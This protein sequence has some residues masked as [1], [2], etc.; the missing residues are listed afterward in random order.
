MKNKCMLLYCTVLC[1]VMTACHFSD[2]LVEKK[3]ISSLSFKKTSLT[4]SVGASDYVSVVVKPVDLQREANISWTVVNPEI[5]DIIPD[6]YNVVINGK[7]EGSTAVKASCDGI[8]ATLMVTVNGFAQTYEQPP[9]LYS[10]FSV[11]ELQPGNTSEVSVSLYGGTSADLEE[12]SWELTDTSIADIHSA[13]NNCVI[14]AKKTGSAQL[15]ARHPKAH[16]AYTMIVFVYADEL[17]EAYLTT[18][19]NIVTIN[20][21]EE[22]ARNL[23]VNLINPYTVNWQ[24]GFNW[25]ISDESEVGGIGIAANG[26]T[27]ILSAYKAGIYRIT[28]THE[29]VRYPLEILVRVI[30]AVKNVYIVPSETNVIL[31]GEGT[32]TIYAKLE[33]YDGAV[34]FN[35]FAWEWE[36]DPGEILEYSVA[37]DA[38]TL[39]GKKNGV[40]KLHVSHPLAELDRTIVVMLTHQA[41]SAIDSA[42]Y[43]TTSSNYVQ[44]Q[45]GADTTE[46]TVTLAGGVAG[47]EKGFVWSIDKGKDNDVALIETTTGV[48]E[49]RAAIGSYAYGTLHITPK[50]MGEVTVTVSHP[51]VSYTT[52]ILIKVYSE[53]A[54]LSPPVYL[55]TQTSLLKLIN[56]NTQEMSVSLSGGNEAGDENAVVWESTDASKVSVNPRTGSTTVFSACGSGQGQTYVNISH[57]KAQADKKILVLTADTQEE[58]EA[59]KAIFASQTYLRLNVGKENK[60]LLEQIGLTESDIA[61]ITW[62]TDNPS[63]CTVSADMDNRLSATVTGYAK[64]EA[65]ITASF[66]SGVPVEFT[67]TVLPEG[68]DIGVIE[69]AYLTTKQNAVVLSDIG[70]TALLSVTGIGISDAS[71]QAD[72]KWETDCAVVEVSGNGTTASVY[73]AEKGKGTVTVSHPESA[74]ELAIDVKVGALYEWSDDALVYITTES[75]VITLVNGDKKTIGAVLENSQSTAPFSWSCSDTSVADITGSASGTCI[76]TAKQAGQA[77]LIIRNDEAV[78]EKEVLIVVENSAAELG[79]FKYLTTEQNVVTVSENANINVAVSVANAAGNIVSGYSWISDNEAVARVVGSGAMAVVYG[80]KAGTAKVTVRNDQCDYPLEIIVNCVDPVVAA[81]YPYIACKNIVTLTVDGDASVVTA[82]LIG[83]S[84]ADTGGFSW[85]IQDPDMVQLYAANETAELRAKKEGVTQLIIGHPKAQGI[86]RTVLIICEPEKKTDCY[87]SVSESIIKMSPTDREK[88]ISAALIGGEAN[89]V[90]N[91]QWWA[92]DYSILDMSYT[93]EQAIITP[94]A[95]GTTTIHVSHPK[96]GNQ[97]DIVIYISQYDE[98]NFAQQSLTMTAGSRNFVDMEI[99]ALNVKTAVSYSSSNPDVVSAS[100][101]SVC[102]LEAHKKGVATVTAELKATATGVIQAKCE[103]LVNVEEAPQSFTYIN[104]PGETIISIEKKVTKTLS[105]TLAGTEAQTGD[106]DTIQ[107]INNNPDVISISPASASGIVTNSQCQI[108]ALKAGN[109]TITITHEKADQELQLYI[110]VPGDNAASIVLNKTAANVILGADAQTLTATIKNAQEGDYE[111]IIW[112]V[113]QDDDQDPVISISGEGKQIAFLAMKAGSATIKAVVPSSRASA[114]C[115]VTVEE[116]RTLTLQYDAINLYPGG[117]QTITYT[118]TPASEMSDITWQTSD[119]AY[120][121][122]FDDHRGRLTIIGKAKEGI[123]SITGITRSKARATMQ[124]NTQ[125]NYLLTLDKNYIN[126]VP[127]NHNDGTWD[128]AY[129]VRPACSEIQVVFDGRA[130]LSVK[131]GQ[132]SSKDG[133]T[134]Y[135]IK[136]HSA[137]DP[138]TGIASGVIHFDVSGEMNLS[139]R[140]GG[141]QINAWNPQGGLLPDGTHSGEI[142]RTTVLQVLAYYDTYNFEIKNFASD[143]NFSRFDKATGCIIVGDGEKVTFTLDAPDATNPNNSFTSATLVS[144]NLNNNKNNK[145][146]KESEN[147]VQVEASGS[148]KNFSVA[149]TTDYTSSDV[150]ESVNPTVKAEYYMGYI[151]FTYK[152]YNNESRSYDVPVYVEIRTCQKGY[153]K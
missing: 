20:T 69:S 2:P 150:V 11:I 77:K 79:S 68:E 141:V 15:I 23:S 61:Q 121:E 46:I 136:N 45:V 90:Y 21:Q 1:V 151:H 75:D 49:A 131:N 148:G 112:S 42:M 84:A 116:A 55:T 30:T 50:A 38:I 56:G 67:V 64:G 3:S 143:G 95:S 37:G 134:L 107:W 109:A 147:I 96:A 73:A 120:F 100:G 133:Q 80:I 33:G 81:E 110:I 86:D 54:Q 135:T 124:V 118:A 71:M 14:N 105:A 28:V 97:K 34:D 17:T 83:G 18:A 19:T 8:T 98:F 66:G 144:S 103:L 127:V 22:A 58:L 87:I 93:G 94:V 4:I 35:R 92:D 91:F 70:E 146:P 152:N 16:Y 125:W 142:G 82:E 47:D 36:E 65:T 39:R 27:A 113:E 74:N 119:S 25:E 149:H 115:T 40:M 104:F 89:D 5:I 85:S 132:K 44:T 88:T 111:N 140:N 48:V 101:N 128:I 63:V 62:K 145:W 108:T 9:Y 106:S 24:Q 52:D 26:N 123:A 72:T 122:L 29:S 117:Q 31:D 43:I 78:A 53:Y 102:I 130:G 137:V 13:R 59:M 76:I 41:G 32:K 7:K 57:D 139:N 138:V 99:P 6:N 153:K 60:L 10:N 12:I 129:E 51:K 126:T 114:L